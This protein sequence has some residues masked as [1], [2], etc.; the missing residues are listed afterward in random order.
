MRMAMLFLLASTVM[1]MAEEPTQPSYWARMKEVGASTLNQAKGAMPD[2]QTVLRWVPGRYSFNGVE[3]KMPDLPDGR[4]IAAG[5]NAWI[6]NGES[7]KGWV[8]S[9]ETISGYMPTLPTISSLLQNGDLGIGNVVDLRQAIADGWALVPQDSKWWTD[10]TVSTVSVGV[11]VGWASFGC[12]VVAT[13]GGP[14]FVALSVAACSAVGADVAERLVRAGYAKAGESI[15]ESALTAGKLT[16][17][18]LGSIVGFQGSEA[19][20]RMMTLQGL[21]WVR[22][23]GQGSD[24]IKFETLQDRG[25]RVAV[26][27]LRH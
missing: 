26:T 16:G 20:N 19:F 14:V 10:D 12:A 27:R 5:L 18:I 1:T 22:E 21:R 3:I 15:D 17:R 4:M 7:M 25:G 13:P 11:V 23:A 6:P 2:R 9:K 8:P 24:A